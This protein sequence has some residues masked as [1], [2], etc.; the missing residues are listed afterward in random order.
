[1]SFW[2]FFTDPVLRAPTWGCLLM[3]IAASLMGVPILLQKRSLLSET[4]SHA[5]YPGVILGISLF[6]ALFPA[7]GDGAFIAVLAG[8]FFSAFL[9]LIAV[10]KLEEKGKVP[11]DAALSFV[12][13]VFFGVG[14]L[15]ASA[16]QAIFPKTQKQVQ[17]LLFGQAATMH[18]GHIFVY[19]VLVLFVVAFFFFF[20]R[21]FQ[22]FLFDKQ[23]AATIQLPVRKV[24]IAFMA[25]F[26]LSLVIGIRSVGVVLLSGMVIAPAVAARQFSDRL[27]TVLGLAGLFGA[28]SGAL[29]N[30][31]SVWGSEKGH[32]LPTGPM[33]VLVGTTFA[34]SALFFAP[35]RGW[36]FRIGRI[37]AFRFRCHR[38]NI[39]KTLWKKGPTSRAVLK[40]RHP[41]RL[42]GLALFVLKGRGW[43][44]QRQGFY[45]LTPVGK[46]RAANIVRLHRLWELY[47]ASSLGF[48]VARVH[49]T[50]EEMEHILS[51]DI[52]KE[53]TQL[54]KNPKTDPHHQPIPEGDL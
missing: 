4:L 48:D 15:G 32:S 54:L 33:I 37:G 16:L 43:M 9:G 8:A 41:T 18:D 3:C 24:E 10:K 50:A 49:H 19:A 34:L 25:L 28:L 2:S 1:M 5:T 53:L 23:F 52:E 46:I 17:T 7:D 27:Q 31:L 38:E 11:S 36:L 51:A 30:V 47:L 6:A 20:F 29:G 35:K 26:L 44:I 21:P 42:L 14:I 39:L 12:L 13:S 40:K 22:A 45:T